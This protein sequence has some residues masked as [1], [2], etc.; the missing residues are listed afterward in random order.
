MHILVHSI[1]CIYTHIYPY[2]NPAVV[3]IC[4]PCIIFPLIIQ[5]GKVWLP[6]SFEYGCIDLNSCSSQRWCNANRFILDMGWLGVGGGLTCWGLSTS[7]VGCCNLVIF[8]A[9]WLQTQWMITVCK[10]INVKLIVLNNS[11]EKEKQ[12]TTKHKYYI[13]FCYHQLEPERGSACPFPD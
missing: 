13:V 4:A 3:M 12:N 6:V 11:I 7:S 10:N 2:L 9:A 1:T 8:Y 5:S